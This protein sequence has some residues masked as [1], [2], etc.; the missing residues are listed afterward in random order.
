[1]NNILSIDIAAKN[2]RT[3]NVGKVSI[4]YADDVVELFYGECISPMILNVK[5]YE[6][7]LD[8]QIVELHKGEVALVIE[9]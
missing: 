9:N 3:L 1:M 8:G 5:D 6:Q 2:F 7:L 4:N